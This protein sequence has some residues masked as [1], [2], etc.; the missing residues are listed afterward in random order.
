MNTSCVYT[1]AGT[2]PSSI[3]SLTALTSLQL[4]NNK[5]TGMWLCIVYVYTSFVYTFAGTIPSSIGSLTKLTQLYLNSN[6]LNGIVL[7]LF[8]SCL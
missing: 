1:F 3:G 8:T 2:I 6:S 7:L 4:D 5:L